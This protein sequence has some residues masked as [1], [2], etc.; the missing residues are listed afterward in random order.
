M[1]TSGVQMVGNST[2]R[3]L[4]AVDG[5]TYPLKS[6]AIS[7][8]AGA[9]VAVA[10]LVQEFENPHAEPLEA[11]YTLPLPADGAVVGYAIQVGERRI[12]GE[13][14][15]REKAT[16]R[17]AEALAS[18]RTAGLLQQER[19][20]TFTQ[21]VGNIPAGVAVRVEIQVV[22]PLAFVRADGAAPE[23]EWRFPTVVGPRYLGDAG[24]VPD[25][26]Q[27]DPPRAA[28]GG[29]PARVTLALEITDGH[30]AEIAPHSPSHAL[31]AASPATLTLADAAHLDRD[32]IVRWKAAAAEPGVRL[33]AGPGLFGDPGRYAVLTITPPAA[34][35]ARVP[36]ALAILL[37]A[38]GS[39]SGKPIEHA[40]AVTIALL[41][42]LGPGDRFEIT[43]FASQ[44]TRLT[45]GLVDA[46]P[47][48]VA[49]A[50]ERVRRLSAGGGTEMLCAIEQAL[51]PT[52]AGE[53][54]QVVLLTDGEVGFEAEVVGRVLR[55]LPAASRVHVVG[56][57]SAPNRALTR[58]LSRRPRPRAA[59]PARGR[60]RRCRRA[61]LRGDRGA[62]AGRRG[63]VRKCGGERGPG[64]GLR[65]LRRA[66]ADAAGRAAGRGRDGRAD[67]DAGGRG[68]AVALERD[69]AGGGCTC[70]GHNRDPGRRAS[71]AASGSRTWR[72]TSPLPAAKRPRSARSRTRSRSP[73][74]ATAS[75][76]AAPA[77]SRSAR[78][79]RS[80]RRPRAAACAWRSS[81]RRTFRR[82]EWGTG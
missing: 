3:G 54:R 5:R 62:G 72:C 59:D 58:G 43:A 60:P 24:R 55:N 10:T 40:K 6:A 57:G 11:I 69:G 65:R 44:P 39:M 38:S 77:W 67:G 4:V 23:W 76:R 12:V 56:V 78:S 45:A 74:C 35:R 47:D 25:A 16:R 27:I 66:A 42:G 48:A 52:R 18:G 81:C 14:E 63:R 36:R 30:A 70:S 37:D 73:A 32:V 8:R 51:D 80:T 13:I 31:Q 17:Y 50:R 49:A 34:P 2:Q 1:A 71:S 26:G 33:V 46:T 75:F 53:Q 41:D 20:D 68:G 29:T 28:N 9:G 15:V 64:A 61:A 82:R 19:A 22:Q 21:R 79:P 7:A